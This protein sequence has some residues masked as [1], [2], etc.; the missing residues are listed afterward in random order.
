MRGGNY[1][2]ASIPSFWNPV[3]SLSILGNS[4]N[5]RKIIDDYL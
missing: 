5:P 1:H 3:S 4:T 2:T